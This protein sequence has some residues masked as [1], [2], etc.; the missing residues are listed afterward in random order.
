MTFRPN[1]NRA[2][3]DVTILDDR[4]DEG[5]E[6]FTVDIESVPPG[7]NV[8]ISNPDSTLISITDNDGE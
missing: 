3:F 7:S 5:T 6:S 1:E 2:C 4:I 8:I